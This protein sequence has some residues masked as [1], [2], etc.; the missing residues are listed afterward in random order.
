MDNS[1][2]HGDDFNSDERIPWLCM[3]KVLERNDPEGRC[4]I[5]ARIPGIM[6]R[7][8]WAIAKGGGSKNE[9]I[10]S[11]PP[12]GADV[13]ITFVN[14]DQR[15]PVWERADY[16]ILDDGTENFP[17]H[18]D[19]DVHVVGIGP[20]R[21]VVDNRSDGPDSKTA[22][23]KLVKKIDGV[24]EDIVWIEISEDN[25][26]QIHADNAIGIDAGAI[27]NIDAA[28]VQILGRK[29]MN[30]SRPIG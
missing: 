11:V 5:R 20:F 1:G 22:R 27:V 17:E 14:G 9:G 29:V 2:F 10:A 28:V 26:I 15:C 8:P 3:G 23:L 13:Y 6:E 7:T 30:V 21:V 4:R 24:E 18:T 19:P 12:I 16:G 25:S